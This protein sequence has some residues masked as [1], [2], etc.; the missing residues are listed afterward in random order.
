MRH[1]IFLAE[2]F[3]LKMY[4]RSRDHFPKPVVEEVFEPEP[5]NANFENQYKENSLRNVPEPPP[6]KKPRYD[7]PDKLE[8]A[9][10]ILKDSRRRLLL[11]PRFNNLREYNRVMKQKN[12]FDKGMK[13]SIEKVYIIYR[14]S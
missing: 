4:E 12:K 6:Q 5:R 11:R 10:R 9:C 2:Q 14:G 7:R 8:E 1:K 13:L 3:Y